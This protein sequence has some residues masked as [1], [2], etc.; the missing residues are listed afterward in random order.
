[1]GAGGWG[2]VG[3]LKQTNGSAVLSIGDPGWHSSQGRPGLHT[4]RE[5]FWYP[6]QSY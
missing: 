1:M 5:S 2:A 6:M 4:V 3:E